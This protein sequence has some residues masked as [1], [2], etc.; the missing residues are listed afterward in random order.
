MR[1]VCTAWL[2]GRKGEDMKRLDLKKGDRIRLKVRTMSG[3]IGSATVIEQVPDTFSDSL[4]W[5]A[6]DGRDP[7][8][9]CC[10]LRSQVAKLR[11]QSPPP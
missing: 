2:R 9:Q 8:E 6:R 5:F 11:D 7:N 3:W 1:L 10:A 4:V